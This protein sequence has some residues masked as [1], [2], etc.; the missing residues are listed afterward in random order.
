MCLR[1]VNAS[2]EACQRAAIAGNLFDGYARPFDHARVSKDEEGRWQCP[3]FDAV[4]RITI[5]G[6][7]HPEDNP[8]NPILKGKFLAFRLN[9]TQC[10]PDV[11]KR[12]TKVLTHFSVDLGEKKRNNELDTACYDYF[13]M[14]HIVHVNPLFLPAEAD[15]YSLK[16]FVMEAEPT[17]D[18][19]SL[20]WAN[21]STIQTL[22]QIH[23]EEV[24]PEAE[25]VM[26][27]DCKRPL[28]S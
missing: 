21:K 2:I 6:T 20:D 9:M 5:L 24:P 17:E 14:T 25:P 26:S 12:R 27:V 22:W 3:A 19:A 10:H 23:F 13:P 16:L 28:V 18:L 11:E 1:Y 8:D 4:V 7:C 15:K